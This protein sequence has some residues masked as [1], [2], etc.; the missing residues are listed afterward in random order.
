MPIIKTNSTRVLTTGILQ[1]QRSAT[2]HHTKS[3]RNHQQVW[4]YPKKG[5]SLVRTVRRF[6]ISPLLLPKLGGGYT[7]TL[8]NF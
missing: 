1:L 2:G 5:V 7:F 6:V 3:S 8:G 4:D